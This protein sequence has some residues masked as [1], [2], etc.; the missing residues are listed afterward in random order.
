MKKL[1]FLAAILVFSYTASAQLLAPKGLKVGKTVDVITI[2]KITSDGSNIKFYSGN[3][4]LSPEDPDTV[5]F[6]SVGV[7]KKDTVN[8]TAGSYVSQHDFRNQATKS[9][10]LRLLN[11]I[12]H[13]VNLVPL[14]LEIG[15]AG[16]GTPAMADGNIYYNLCYVLD[17]TILSSFMFSLSTAGV[18]TG[19]NY[20]GIGIYRSSNDTIYK[21]SETANNANLWKATANVPA[22]VSLPASVTLLPGKYV[23]ACLYNNSAQTTAPSMNGTT[24]NLVFNGYLQG[25]LKV[26]GY[27]STSGQ[28]T[29]P[30]FVKTN[31]IF[32]TSSGY[33]IFGK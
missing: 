28:N 1:I 24:T 11:V 2:S 6:G 4:L 26:S 32:P 5:D 20:N 13:P 33:I 17:T 8:V 15:G 29:L 14:A 25:G 7:L 16:M 3:K 31:F 21:I 18:Y 9:A 12:G 19:D 22:T 30:A 10:T 23:I 27:S